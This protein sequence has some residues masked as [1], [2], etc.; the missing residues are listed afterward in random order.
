MESIT[1][2]VDMGSETSHMGS[3]LGKLGWDLE[4]SGSVPVN[5]ITPTTKMAAPQNLAYF[6]RSKLPPKN[7]A[8]AKSQF[9]ARGMAARW[10]G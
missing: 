7:A 9:K 8:T 6:R 2:T 1:K 5:Q 10:Q 4:N 3:E